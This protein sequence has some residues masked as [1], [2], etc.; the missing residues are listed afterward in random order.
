MKDRFDNLVIP[1]DKS[2]G[3]STY[4]VIR[5]FRK[6]VRA[7]KVGHSGTLD[8]MATG[9]V[10]ILTGAATKLSNYL[11][12]LP[13]RY[14][15][16]IRL[17]EATD[18]QDSTGRVLRS[19]GWE[20]VGEEQIREVL[21]GFI[22]RRMQVPPM[23]S[24]LKHKGTPLYALA[25]RGQEIER[26][27]REV[28]THEIELLGCDLPIFRIMVR[29][30]RGMYVRVLAEEIGDALGVP[31][32]LHSLVRTEV[33]H[34][35]LDSA[36]KDTDFAALAGREKPGYSLSEALIHMPAVEL[37]PVQARGLE[38]GIAPRIRESFPQTG[39][40]MRL[41]RPDGEL[42]AIAETGAAGILHLKKVFNVAPAGD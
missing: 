15:A 17:G 39:V 22:G 32:C 26:A 16:D 23:Y 12:E 29:C 5:R 18:T 19:A 34:F 31:A 3:L 20:G 21:P 4:D 2:A 8:P 13:K 14:I 25:R 27:P 6:T 38:N 42:G 36:V 10:L 28:V 33:G 9:L 24:A 11:M 40:Y 35:N 1:V 30:S 7:D 41:I 37:T